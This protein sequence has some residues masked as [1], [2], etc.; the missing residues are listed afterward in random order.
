MNIE[1][2]THLLESIHALLQQE[3]QPEV[4]IAA[5]KGLLAIEEYSYSQSLIL[6]TIMNQLNNNNE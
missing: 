5:L 1:K 3:I 6:D 2:V 4:R